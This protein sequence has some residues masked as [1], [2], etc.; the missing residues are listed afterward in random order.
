M[1]SLFPDADATRRENS[2]TSAERGALVVSC[3]P[4]CK[5]LAIQAAGGYAAVGV[6]VDVDDL[7]SEA[8]LAATN[9]SRFYDEARGVRF[10]TYATN[11]IKTS[12]KAFVDGL[13]GLSSANTS[14]PDLIPQG[15][16]E[17][18]SEPYEPNDSES[19][20]LRVLD[21]PDRSIVRLVV[22]GDLRPEQVA[23]QLGI[24]VKDVKLRIRNAVA[25]VQDWQ[26]RADDV[27]LRGIQWEKANKDCFEGVVQ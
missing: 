14:A 3:L 27:E 25:K 23:V 6:H 1:S 8:H 10:I 16:A 20:I 19:Q 13:G 15:V 21:E 4:W 26:A 12:F 5:R 2:L 9:A 17:D 7:E 24:P 22:F 11:W 18:E